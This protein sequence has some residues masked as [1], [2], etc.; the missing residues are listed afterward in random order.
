M[1]G[2]DFDEALRIQFRTTAQK[3]AKGEEVPQTEYRQMLGMSSIM[4]ADLVEMAVS[5]DE[6]AKAI[7][8]C[9]DSAVCGAET[10]PRNFRQTIYTI[11]THVFSGAESRYVLAALLALWMTF[12]YFGDDIRAAI[13]TSG[14]VAAAATV[15]NKAES[16]AEK[17]IK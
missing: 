6:L 14:K 7:Q 5:K 9:R 2:T 11:M 4:V 13:R 8:A 16:V 15:A 10:T 1:S 17:F 12:W 3:M